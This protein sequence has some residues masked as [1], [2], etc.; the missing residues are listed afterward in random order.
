L[1]SL[2][3]FILFAHVLGPLAYRNKH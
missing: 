2:F 1:F 3:Y